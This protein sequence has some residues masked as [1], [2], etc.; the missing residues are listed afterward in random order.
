MK[1]PGLLAYFFVAKAVDGMVI[2][3]PRRLH[4]RVHDGRSDELEAALDQV[5][6][7][8]IGERCS[9]RELVQR[10]EAVLDRLAVVQ[11]FFGL[12][13]FRPCPAQVPFA[14]ARGGITV[15]FQE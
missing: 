9:G 8:R 2:H 4:M 12:A 3:H 15:L 7:D 6:A 10:R 11:V 5:F 14:D 1:F 13:L